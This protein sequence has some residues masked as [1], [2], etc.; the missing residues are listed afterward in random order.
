MLR[1]IVKIALLISVFA[2]PISSQ[3][4]TYAVSVADITN[5][6]LTGGTVNGWTFSQDMAI[7][8]ATVLAGGAM[9]D[10]PASCA[11]CG[12]SNN[13]IAHNNIG[14]DYSYGDA[15]ISNPSI[16][17][18]GSAASIAEAYVSGTNTGAAFSSNSMTAFLTVGAS[19][20]VSFDFDVLSY[21]T[22]L[23]TTAG[24]FGTAK[25]NVG[26]S[27]TPI[28]GSTAIWSLQPGALNV[29]AGPGNQTYNV[30]QHFNG[31]ANLVAGTTYMLNISMSQEVSA[32]SAIPVPAAAWLFGSGLIGLLGVARRRAH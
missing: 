15:L 10:A 13:F 25:M 14:N 17:S 23:V 27:I 20:S 16:T 24:D 7:N 2:A 12:F 19:G 9:I 21:L 18:G 8:G 30:N 11:S 26:I 28:G 1:N 5:F 31:L 29:F 22:V 6:T 3:A 32:T 4:S